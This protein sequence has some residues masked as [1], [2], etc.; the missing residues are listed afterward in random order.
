MKVM[1]YFAAFADTLGVL[2][3]NIGP[4]TFMPLA[5]ECVQLGLGLLENADDPDLRRCM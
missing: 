1:F 3:R 4:E 5:D 2:A